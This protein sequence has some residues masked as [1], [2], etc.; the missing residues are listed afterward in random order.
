MDP[1]AASSSSSPPPV[2][3]A[4]NPR[5]RRTPAHVFFLVRLKTLSHR[6]NRNR[7]VSQNSHSSHLAQHVARALVVVSFRPEQYLTFLMHPQ[8]DLLSDHP[9]ELHCCPLHTET[10]CADPSTES[11]GHLA[12]THSSSGYEPKDLTEEDTSIL[13]KQTFFHR[14]SMTS[15]Y[16]SAESIATH[17][18]E[19]DLDGEQI[20]TMLALP[21]YLQE[22]EASADRSRVYHS[23]RENS[24]SSSYHFR[25]SAGKAHTKE[26]R[27]KKHFPTEKAFPQDI[28]QLK[29]R[30]KLSSGFLIQKK[31][32]D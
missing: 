11:F 13:V 3:T 17:P 9:P 6:V 27:E 7:C 24:V 23:F 2:N 12:E 14:P 28:N 26:S 29:E 22:R 20:R 8:S 18:P 15:T 32:R 19:S 30:V 5:I 4:P 21:L 16:D 25:E 10:Y 31:L 1:P